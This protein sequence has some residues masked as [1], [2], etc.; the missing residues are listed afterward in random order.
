MRIFKRNNIFYYLI[1]ISFSIFTSISPRADT[2]ELKTYKDWSVYKRQD[3]SGLICFM[4]SV[5]KKLLGDYERKNRGETRVFV[6]HG[7]G[8]S[9]RNVVSVLA[10]YNYKKH[11]EVTFEIN[12]SEYILFTL[13]NRAWS[14]GAE[15][16]M[17]LIN[18][19]KR[20][21]KL[22]V[23]GV[24]SRENKTIDEYSLSGFTLAKKFLDKSCK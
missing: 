1:F 11:S 3:N 22:I 6:S 13:E 16:D 17:N 12:K 15:E 2:I 20:G 18:A 21:K 23:T 7:P 5:P 8:S 14:P 10:G 9:E 19:M 24:S 4:S